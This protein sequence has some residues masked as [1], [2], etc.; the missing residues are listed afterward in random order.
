MGTLYDVEYKVED[1][2][3]WISVAQDYTSAAIIISGIDGTQTY[4][5]RVQAKSADVESAWTKDGDPLSAR[6]PAPSHL[7]PCGGKTPQGMFY[8]TAR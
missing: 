7:C 8:H 3:K 2:T 1:D 6:A 4:V 5:A